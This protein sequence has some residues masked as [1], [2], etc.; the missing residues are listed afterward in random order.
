M[1]SN[2][3]V[4]PRE[5]TTATPRVS[6]GSSADARN[7]I[8]LGTSTGV[9]QDTGNGQSNSGLAPSTFST[10]VPS[11]ALMGSNSKDDIILGIHELSGH[12]QTHFSTYAT[13]VRER[14][15]LLAEISKVQGDLQKERRT[16]TTYQDK[17]EE[18]LGQ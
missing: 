8:G 17:H 4:K 9:I 10:P 3:F 2:R 1:I 14:D 12:L 18:V 15:D 7:R 5:E 13:V 16:A 6:A 11:C